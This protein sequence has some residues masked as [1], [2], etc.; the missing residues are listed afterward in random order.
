VHLGETVVGPRCTD[1]HTLAQENAAELVDYGTT[2][3]D[4]TALQSAI[5]EFMTRLGE[6][7]KVIVSRKQVTDELA[8]DEEAADKVLKNELDPSMRKFKTKNPSFFGEYSSAR[9]IIDLGT[10]HEKPEPPANG[11]TTPPTPPSS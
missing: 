4:I 7:R 8:G 5:D 2:A 10:R 6:P 3:E 9:M 1:I 11:P